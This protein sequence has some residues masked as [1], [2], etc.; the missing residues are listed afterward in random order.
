[1][2][3]QLLAN[4]ITY[5]LCMVAA[6]LLNLAVSALVVKI[7]NLLVAPDFFVIAIVRAVTGIVTSCAVLGAVIGYKGYKTLSFSFLTT[8]LSVFLAAVAHFLLALLLRFYP[9]IAGGTQY[10]GGIL[11]SGSNFT[12]FE[13]VSDVHLLAYIGAFWIAKGAEIIVAPISCLLGKR[14]RLKNRETIKGYQN[15]D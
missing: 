15:H 12:S 11:E 2:K 8:V 5:L 14:R 7:V 13:V 4:G 3:K 9:F 6:A 1:M 10:L